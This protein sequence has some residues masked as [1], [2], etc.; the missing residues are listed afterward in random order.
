MSFK[1]EL[2]I[3]CGRKYCNKCCK[4]LHDHTS[5]CPIFGEV[6]SVTYENMH[7][8]VKHWHR[9]PAC[10][11]AEKRAKTKTVKG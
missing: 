5:V 8:Y 9:L 4:E 11:E 10:I 1:V 7:G 6:R 3:N 2:E